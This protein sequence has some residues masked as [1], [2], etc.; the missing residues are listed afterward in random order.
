M[1]TILIKV[2]VEQEIVQDEREGRWTFE[3][4]EW[5]KFRGITEGRIKEVNINQEIEE[6][7]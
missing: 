4:A 7:K 6:Q 1:I 3:E 5:G 2:G